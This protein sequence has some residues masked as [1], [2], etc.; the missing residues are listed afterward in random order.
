[1]RGRLL[2]YVLVLVILLGTSCSPVCEDRVPDAA[3]EVASAL[4]QR[5]LTSATT[6]DRSRQADS[7]SRIFAQLQHHL[8]HSAGCDL[9][10]ASQH[11]L[12]ILAAGRSGS[13]TLLEMVNQI[14]GIRL[15][16]ENFG[17][18][19]DLRKLADNAQKVDHIN[20]LAMLHGTI[21]RTDVLCSLQSY[22]RS[23]GGFSDS[24][25]I[26]GFKEIRHNNKDDLA[27][28]RELFPCARFIVNMRRNIT[29][30]IESRS[31]LGWK[32]EDYKVKEAA[33]VL[34]SWQRKHHAISYLMRLEDDFTTKGFNN[35]L[36]WLG[37][38][39]C[40]FKSVVHKNKKGYSKAHQF[41]AWYSRRLVK[42]TC[43]ILPHHGRRGKGQQSRRG[44]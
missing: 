27:F 5:H 40:Q 36:S 20:T 32:T 28:F 24:D 4:L 3:G 21:N 8:I 6:A 31:N 11:W 44:I 39:G 10:G 15:A 43:R 7:S 2:Q 25:E 35:L 19:S 37:V 42:G 9:C 26:I 34:E 33:E 1:M 14:P 41:P 13:T 38:K 18:L 23:I 12:F 22:V 29:A 17:G 16:G 30:L